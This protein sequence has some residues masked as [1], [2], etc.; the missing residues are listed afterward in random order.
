MLPVLK[1]ETSISLPVKSMVRALAAD[2]VSSR[3]AAGT[4]DGNVILTDDFTSAKSLSKVLYN[5]N[6][7][8]V[9]SI[10]FAKGKNWLVSSSTDKTIRIWIWKTKAL[11]KN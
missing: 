10:A 7:N 3:L 1:T 8:R 11:L 2:P 6:N 5:H 9:L 4:L